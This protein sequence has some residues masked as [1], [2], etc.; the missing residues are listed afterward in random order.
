MDRWRGPCI[1]G[2]YNGIFASLRD[3]CLCPSNNMLELHDFFKHSTLVELPLHGDGVDF[4]WSR[5]GVDSFCSRLD[6]FLASVDRKDNSC[7]HF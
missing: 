3:S 5:S 4:T 1:G 7:T 6:G 2:G